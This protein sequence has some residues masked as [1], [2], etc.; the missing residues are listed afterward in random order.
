MKAQ[1]IERE[2]SKE[3]ALDAQ[4]LSRFPCPF[5]FPPSY[6]GSGGMLL[7]F[8]KL[9]IGPLLCALR[10]SGS[11]QLSVLL[12]TPLQP[13]FPPCLSLRFWS[14]FYENSHKLYY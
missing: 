2:I 4:I 8:V 7:V 14:H 9:K 6:L 13:Q 10:A 1:D 5:P 3:I 12:P 11:W